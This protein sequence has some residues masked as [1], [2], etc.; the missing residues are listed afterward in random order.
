M[1]YAILTTAFFVTSAAAVAG[2]STFNDVS[3]RLYVPC[4]LLNIV[5]QYSTQ[6]S[7]ACPGDQ[8]ITL[9]SLTMSTCLGL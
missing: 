1:L 9:T 5:R 2:V 8:Q 3:P 7:V 6:T 4:P